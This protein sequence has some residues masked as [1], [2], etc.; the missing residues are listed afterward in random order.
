M[1]LGLLILMWT[2]CKKRRLMI[3]GIV[4]SCEPL[5]DTPGEDLQNSILKRETSQWIDV[6]REETDKD[7]NDYQTRLCLA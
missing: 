2:S 5:S 4:A 7:S 6:V 3:T 1:L